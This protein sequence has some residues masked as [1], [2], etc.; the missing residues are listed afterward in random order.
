MINAILVDGNT[1]IH[2]P[3]SRWGQEVQVKLAQM[4]H[5]LQDLGPAPDIDTRSEEEKARV[6]ALLDSTG[7]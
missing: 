3:G 2:L 1:R 5:V 6:M 7:L 4:G